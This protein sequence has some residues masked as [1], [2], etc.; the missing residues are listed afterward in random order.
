MLK[1]N[2][3]FSAMEEKRVMELEARMALVIDYLLCWFL[4]G[5]SHTQINAFKFF[6]HDLTFFLEVFTL[7][8]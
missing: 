2:T 3:A 4:E 5:L 8:N 7:V 6:L 1:W